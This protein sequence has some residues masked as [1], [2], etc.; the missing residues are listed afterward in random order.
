MMTNMLYELGEDVNDIEQRRKFDIEYQ[1]YL[2]KEGKKRP[3][4]A[5]LTIATPAPE[6]P[7]EL[8]SVPP[9]D[10]S[11]SRHSSQ[12]S[13]TLEGQDRRFNNSFCHFESLEQNLGGW[14]SD[15]EVPE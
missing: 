5:R 6:E 7:P 13:E 3:S 15:E 12:S 4:K 2:E 1:K 11:P 14:E 9:D 8:L 10:S